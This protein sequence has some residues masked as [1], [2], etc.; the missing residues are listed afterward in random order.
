MIINF[1]VS[2]QPWVCTICYHS[3]M[4]SLGMLSSATLTSVI[5]YIFSIS[6]N[7][8]ASIPKILTDRHFAMPSSKEITL[9]IFYITAS[10]FMGMIYPPC[11]ESITYYWC[12][13]ARSKFFDEF[14]SSSRCIKYKIT[15]KDMQL[16]PRKSVAESRPVVGA[17]VEK[18]L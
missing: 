10:N 1:L 2:Y 16:G 8:N 15:D 18:R 17:E 11:H 7:L 14:N 4:K 5:K 9:W 6:S 12:C 13:P 3:I